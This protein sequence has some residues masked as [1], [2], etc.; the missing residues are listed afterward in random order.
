MTGIIRN[1][2]DLIQARFL[3]GDIS[4]PSDTMTSGPAS[5]DLRGRPSIITH[6]LNG[7]ASAA[8]ITAFTLVAENFKAR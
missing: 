6:T 3:D 4:P 7:G 5:S 2:N 8:F 1:R